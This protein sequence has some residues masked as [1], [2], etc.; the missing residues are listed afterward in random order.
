[1]SLVKSSL[2][3]QSYYNLESIFSAFKQKEMKAS[4]RLAENDIITRGVTVKIQ[5]V[6]VRGNYENPT[7]DAKGED[8]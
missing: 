8:E 5:Q 1:M 2:E 7:Y 4:R 3:N 6:A